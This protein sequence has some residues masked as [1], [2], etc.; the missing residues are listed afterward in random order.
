MKILIIGQSVVDSI[1]ED[2]KI[3]IKPGGIF[4]SA[5]AAVS[6]A[7]KDNE[8]FLCTSLTKEHEYLFEEVYRKISKTYIEYRDKI[9]KV[10]LTIYQNRERDER[11]ENVTRNLNIP[12]DKLQKF[13]GIFINMITG[14]DITLEQLEHIRKKFDGLIYFDVHTF[15]RGLDEDGNRRLRRIPGFK[16]WAAC[17]DIIQANEE[18]LKTVSR[19]ISENEIVRE[20]L[21]C[22]VKQVIITKA[23]K[24][25]L[26]YFKSEEDIESVYI[27][28]IKVKTRNKVGCGDVFGAVYFYSYIRT[29]DVNKSLRIANIAAGCSATYSDIKE[30]SNLKKDVQ[31]RYS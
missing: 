2:G 7:E 31:Q 5:V 9:P 11:Y 8:I 27:P 18:E 23:E 20:L 13:A 1:N 6:V 17:V 24:G 12:V 3:S 26:V 16:K 29:K 30:F 28:A 25:V 15:S 10:N 14:F 22:G 4:Y 19:K 21:F